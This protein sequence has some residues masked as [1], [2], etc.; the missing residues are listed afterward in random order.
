MDFMFLHSL[1]SSNV[2]E[3]SRN[4]THGENDEQMDLGVEKAADFSRR[5]VAAGSQRVEVPH[6]LLLSLRV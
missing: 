6:R 5:D 1:V 2:A 4:Y 3:K